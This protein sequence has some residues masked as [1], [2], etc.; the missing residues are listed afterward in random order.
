M[1]RRTEIT[2]K[3]DDYDDCCDECRRAADLAAA[4]TFAN[5]PRCDIREEPMGGGFWA[6]VDGVEIG[7]W[8]TH[9]QAFESLVRQGVKVIQAERGEREAIEYAAILKS[10]RE[11]VAKMRAEGKHVYVYGE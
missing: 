4:D 7:L 3:C 9:D 8:E 2:C 5:G 6:I 1:T 10:H 11:W